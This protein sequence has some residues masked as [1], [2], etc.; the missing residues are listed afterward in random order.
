MSAIKERSPKRRRR[1]Q[2]RRAHISARPR[3]IEAKTRGA[4]TTCR[5]EFTASPPV[6][7]GAAQRCAARKP[8]A[9]FPHAHARAVPSC[10]KP[11]RG[12]C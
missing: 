1:Q 7:K 4:V 12:A 10:K 5:G 3:P 9:P 6:M 8:A 11:H 2:R